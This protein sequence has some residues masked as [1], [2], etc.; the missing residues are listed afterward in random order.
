[1]FHKSHCDSG[2]DSHF[3]LVMDLRAVERCGNRE[4]VV[5]TICWYAWARILAGKSVKGTQT[6]MFAVK[7]NV[8]GKTYLL[9]AFYLHS[10]C[11][12]SDLSICQFL[13]QAMLHC[14]RLLSMLTMLYFFSSL[15]AMRY[16]CLL[17]T[18]LYVNNLGCMV[19]T[20]SCT[21]SILPGICGAIGRHTDYTL[22]NLTTRFP[23]FPYK[24]AVYL[25]QWLDWFVLEF[26]CLCCDLHNSVHVYVVSDIWFHRS[27]PPRVTANLMV[28]WK[29][30]PTRTRKLQFKFLHTT[31][32]YF[33]LEV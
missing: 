33:K 7:V 31:L 24:L 12:M 28:Y 16:G 14:S 15:C 10:F 11:M 8:N 17:F 19:V 29:I 1:M 21:T 9:F 3:D 32:R 30:W 6:N 5:Y 20:R 23:V 26:V 2:S 27:S 18:Y 13:M 22:T 25:L 4:A